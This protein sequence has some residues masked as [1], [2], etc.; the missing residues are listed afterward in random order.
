MT[1]TPEESIAV[2]PQGAIISFSGQIADIP[3]G[4]ALCDGTNGTPDLTDSF[5][6]GAG[7]TL[8]PNDTGGSASETVSIEGSDTVNISGSDTANITVSDT[9]SVSGQTG[10]MRFQGFGTTVDSS[11]DNFP[12]EFGHDSD[13]SVT[14]PHHGRD[15][16]M[17]TQVSGTLNTSTSVTPLRGSFSGSGSVN[18]SGSDTINISGSD[19]VSISDSQTVDT[20]P[21]FIALAYIQKL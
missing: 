7:G 9:V 21:Q 13:K 6:Q 2:V 11:N 19:T 4:F 3:D 10:R 18:A 5:I 12:S 20:Q 8:N 16:V 14:F 17:R 15:E 1:F